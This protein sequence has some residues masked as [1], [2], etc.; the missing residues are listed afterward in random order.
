MPQSIIVRVAA[1]IVAAAARAGSANSRLA[2]GDVLTLVVDAG[3][4]LA[5]CDH[6]AVMD[7]AQMV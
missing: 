2:C 4:G 7:L 1:F 3:P 6:S 5:S